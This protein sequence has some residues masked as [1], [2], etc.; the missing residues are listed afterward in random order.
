MPNFL[1]S[2]FRWMYPIPTYHQAAWEVGCWLLGRSG[3]NLLQ[4]LAWHL[5]G[6]A[7]GHITSADIGSMVHS[8]P[9]GGRSQLTDS[10]KLGFCSHPM[11]GLRWTK[12]CCG[13]SNNV[14]STSII[15]ALWSVVVGEATGGQFLSSPKVCPLMPKLNLFR[16]SIIRSCWSLKATI[17]SKMP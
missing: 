9:P 10:D 12:V 13:A 14:C 11:T 3:R 15:G 4:S 16:R 2:Q 8:G 7:S 5:N 17:A 6:T 1:L